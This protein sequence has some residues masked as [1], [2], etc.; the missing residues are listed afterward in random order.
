METYGDVVLNNYILRFRHA[1]ALMPAACSLRSFLDLV[2]SGVE[3][4]W[5]G[6]ACPVHCGPPAFTSL[7]P[8]LLAGL[9]IGLFA[10]FTLAFFLAFRSGFLSLHPPFEVGSPAP[11]AQRPFSR[12]WTAPCILA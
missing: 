10:G 1:Q 3:S 6:L 4:N 12:T 8:S 5:W 7:A 11:R 9:G 2:R